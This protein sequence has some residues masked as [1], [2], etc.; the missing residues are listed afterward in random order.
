MT[1]LI[2]LGSSGILALIDM[3]KEGKKF[4]IAPRGEKNGKDKSAEKNY[5]GVIRYGRPD[6]NDTK[7]HGD[8]FLKDRK[9][10]KKHK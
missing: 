10:N 2:N 3:K 4:A 8:S 7:I 9:K 1:L 6:P 5:T